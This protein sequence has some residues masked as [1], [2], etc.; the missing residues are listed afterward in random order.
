MTIRMRTEATTITICR[1]VAVA[2]TAG[3][4]V[5]HAAWAAGATWP[6]P[7][8]DQLADLV[9][10]RRP[11][12]GPGP[13]GVVVGLLGVTAWAV[14]TVRPPGEG[15]GGGIE[16]KVARLGARVAA[17]VLVARGAG[18]LVAS[19]R[20]LGR[21]TP[22]FRHWDLRLYSPA[23]LGLGLATGVVAWAR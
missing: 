7:D 3:M 19:A 11:M 2:G 12:P 1:R 14:A 4:A 18:G 22:T 17:A 8:R 6:A 10:G 9:V 15:S 13:T 20:E 16:S 23:A 21:A 5:L